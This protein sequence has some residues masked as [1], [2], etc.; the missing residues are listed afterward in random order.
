MKE[1]FISLIFFCL[2]NTNEMGKTGKYYT[3]I[4]TKIK[5]F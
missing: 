4:L 1:N 3:K 5:K 2:N